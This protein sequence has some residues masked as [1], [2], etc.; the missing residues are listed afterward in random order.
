[1]WLVDA[2]GRDRPSHGICLDCYRRL[3][4]I[5]D[6]S[7]ARL[8]EFPFGVIIPTGSV[9]LQILFLHKA[10]EGVVVVRRHA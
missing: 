9:K 2:G 5:P 10:A 3:R 7:E 8:G 1:M 4:G 6:L